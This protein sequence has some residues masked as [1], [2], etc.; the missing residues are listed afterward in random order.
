[1]VQEA[2]GSRAGTGPPPPMTTWVDPW[3]SLGFR[4]HC[5]LAYCSLLTT[6]DR[7]WVLVSSPSLSPCL[8]VS[9]ICPPLGV[10]FCHQVSPP[11]DLWVWVSLSPSPLL[12]TLENRPKWNLVD[13]KR[14]HCERSPQFPQTNLALEDPVHCGDTER[15]W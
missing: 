4:S 7:V 14:C 13:Q 3:V 5:L 8:Y 6:W 12:A 15:L 11:P 9:S 1:M 2:C 10:S